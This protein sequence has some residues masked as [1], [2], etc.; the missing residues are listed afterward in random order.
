[1]ENRTAYNAW[2]NSYDHMPNKTRDLE[3][4]VLKTLLS[5]KRFG[6][7]LEI[8]CGTG[9]NTVFLSG[10]SQ[11]VLGVDFSE[12]M[13]EK[14]RVK[15]LPSSVSFLQADIQ[16][17]WEFGISSFDLV[18]FSLVL[19][20]IEDLNH[21]FREATK[22]LKP[23]GYIYIGELHPFKQYMGSKAKFEAEGAWQE[24]QCFTHHISDFFEAA[25]SSGLKCV[26]LKE[27]FDGG[28]PRILSFL[29]EK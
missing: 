23:G 4:E 17:S 10:I 9:K 11:S 14:A 2:S 22:V 21:I 15:N 16:Q 1:M 3:A 7:T 8:G 27:C 26:S 13:L 24:L 19:E 29:F 12:G 20:H 25:N 28:P 6:N 5:N 18:T